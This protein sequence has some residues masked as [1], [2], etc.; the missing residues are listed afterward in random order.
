MTQFACRIRSQGADKGVAIR[1]I[2]LWRKA[3]EGAGCACMD[4]QRRCLAKSFLSGPRV[5]M[6][7][8]AR[9]NMCKKHGAVGAESL[10]AL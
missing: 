3:S 8:R 4:L 7:V 9:E 10:K 2:A 5:R 6:R 1:W